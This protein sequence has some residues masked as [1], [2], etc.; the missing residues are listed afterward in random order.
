MEKGK[1]L[2]RKVWRLFSRAGFNTE[3]SESNQAE[4]IVRVSPN[5]TRN[6]DLYATDQDLGVSI[7]G[8]NKSGDVES[9]SAH[10]HDFE[11]IRKCAKGN[12]LLFVVT[13]KKLD[14]SDLEVA[15]KAKAAVWTSK[16][17][18][19][20]EALVDTIGKYAK[21]EIL[22]ALGVQTK[23][24]DEYRSVIA[25]RIR[26]PKTENEFELYTFTLSPEKL[27]RTCV[28]YRK[29]LDVCGNN[30][31]AY[32]RMINKRRLP[33][34]AEFVSKPGSILP[35]NIIVHL[36]DDVEV[37]P[38]NMNKLSD[39]SD[40]PIKFKQQNA[41]I[42]RLNIPMRYAS[43]ELIDGQH[44]LF[45]FSKVQNSDLL[46]K[47]NL[48][49]LGI[50]GLEEPNKAK[51]FVA[52]NDNSRRMDPNLV[53]YLKYTDDESSCKNDH[54]LMA[55]K[56]VVELNRQTP[57][58]DTIRMVDV[59]S[60]RITLKG[61]SGYD[62]QGLVGEKGLLRKYYPNNASK[63]YVSA[64]RLYFSCIRSLFKNEWNNP[65]E[66]IIATNRGISAF[67][68]LLKAIIRTEKKQLTQQIVTRYIKTLK[69]NWKESWKTINLKAS[70]VGTQGWSRLYNEMVLAIRKTYRQFAESFK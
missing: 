47:Y 35:V 46:S 13:G 59:G 2:N 34:I 1:H 18:A 58:L 11:E 67:L 20:F 56:I 33:K 57:F 45:G 10:V 54:K 29:A 64:L 4:H 66:Y 30:A 5:K 38:L 24:E 27:L 3:P 19:Y 28:I 39:A 69:R 26:Q 40:K 41:D 51:T 14:K 49:V 7:I 23:E 9:W 42:V 50:K 37:L 25:L 36:T 17:L 53:S 68:K 62:L 63:E 12:K 48:V 55:I 31:K 32:Q 6:V 22:H 21:F 52:I 16:D 8:S 44:R 15:E 70:F 65:K 43:L 60:Q 61:F